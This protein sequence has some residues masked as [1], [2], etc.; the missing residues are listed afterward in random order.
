MWLTINLNTRVSSLG[1]LVRPLCRFPI[2]NVVW[3]LYLTASLVRLAPLD[4]HLQNDID[5]PCTWLP[6][7][8]E[9]C[10]LKRQTRE[11]PS[12]CSNVRRSIFAFL[13]WVRYINHISIYSI[14]TGPH[15]AYA[16]A[17]VVYGLYPIAI[18]FPTGFSVNKLRRHFLSIGRAM[19]GY[20]FAPPSGPS[21][22]GHKS[23][24]P[25][26]YGKLLPYSVTRVEAGANGEY[27]C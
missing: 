18:D 15:A 1:L 14:S 16:S 24:H 4:C 21:R 11:A 20:S 3:Q 25:L 6:G 12:V 10:D 17:P 26:I 27:S 19:Q 7:R 9:T 8:L 13:A 22:E 23:K 2:W 5:S